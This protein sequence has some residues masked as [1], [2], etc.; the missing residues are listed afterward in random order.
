MIPFELELGCVISVFLYCIQQLFNSP[1]TFLE[2]GN[3]EGRLPRVQLFDLR[4]PGA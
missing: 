4:E 3:T 2:C 1:Q